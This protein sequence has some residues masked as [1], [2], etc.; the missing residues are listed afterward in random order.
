MGLGS[1]DENDPKPWPIPFPTE[2][3]SGTIS[4]HAYDPADAVELFEALADERVWKHMSRHVPADAATLDEVIRAKLA[5]EYWT[6]FAVRRRGRAVGISSVVFDPDH[7]DGAE[8]GGTLLDPGVWGTGA[9]TGDQTNAARG[10]LPP[11][12]RVRSA[13]HRRTQPA[14][15]RRDPEARR[16]GAPQPR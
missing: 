14:V 9:N 16:D 11:R 1:V 13:A 6:T 2:M 10:A 8:V 4:M 7:P 5:D 3:S 12:R 15:G